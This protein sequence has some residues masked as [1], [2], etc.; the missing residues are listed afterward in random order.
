V[1]SGSLYHFFPSKEALLIG[2]LEYLIEHL[3]PL[4]MDPAEA[5]ASDPIERIFSLMAWYRAG[6]EHTS[7]KMGCP[8]GNLA[9]EVGDDYP[10]AR[11]LIDQNF[12]N[13]ALAV[14]RWLD[15]AA[16][17]FPAGTDRERL[18]HFV[19]TVME[20]GIMQSRAAGN[21]RPFDDSVAELRA[22]L[23]LLIER[24]ADPAA[25]P[26]SPSARP[27]VGATAAEQSA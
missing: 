10:E 1:N 24:G 21:L 4:V 9:L 2:V 18:A 16:D 17:R 11:R 19:L 20:G 8:V 26:L 22:Y 15:A 14:K 7:C 27:D 6:L 25:P 3:R 5:R 12:R 23:N 13:W